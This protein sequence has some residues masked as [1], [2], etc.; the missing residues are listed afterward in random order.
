MDDSPRPIA[1]LKLVE[2]HALG[3]A[4]SGVEP[5][6]YNLGRSGW[7]TIYRYA[8]TPYEMLREWIDESYRA[9]APKALGRALDAGRELERVQRRSS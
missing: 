6:R 8:D 5:M 2:S 4:Q 1:G 3:L 7:V 9:V